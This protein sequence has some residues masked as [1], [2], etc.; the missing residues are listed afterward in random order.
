M[1]TG[2]EGEIMLVGRMT[3]WVEK[4]FK[5][6]DNFVEIDDDNLWDRLWNN[7]LEGSPMILARFFTLIL[8]SV[9]QIFAYFECWDLL[10]YQYNLVDHP[11]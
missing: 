2:I 7:I 4:K 9:Q 5:E 6:K 11:I 1:H 3:S 10:P 8:T